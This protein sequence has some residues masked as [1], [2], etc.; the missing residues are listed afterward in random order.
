MLSGDL[1]EFFQQKLE[2]LRVKILDFSRTNPLINTRMGTSYQNYIRVI[3]EHPEIILNG[4]EFSEFELTPLPKLEDEP[5]DELNS[6]FENRFKELLVT[7]ELYFEELLRLEEENDTSQDSLQKA[8]RELKDRIR[9]ELKMPPRVKRDSLNLRQHA[10]NNDINPN[11]DLPTPD[12]TH[13]DGRHSDSKIQTLLLPKDLERL[14]GKIYSRGKSS[15]LE[16]GINTLHAAFGFLEWIELDGEKEN[17]SPLVIMPLNLQRRPSADGIKYLIDSIGE[18]GKTNKV[19]KEKLKQ[20]YQIEFP[21]F[22]GTSIEDYF[23]I[24]DNL[25]PKNFSK[26]NIKRF[27][28]FGNF[29][30]AQM[31]MFNDLKFDNHDYE[32]NQLVQDLLIGT[33]TSLQDHSFAEDYNNDIPEIENEVPNLVMDADSSQFS[34]LVDIQRGKNLAIEGPPGTGKS[35]TIVNAIVSAIASGKKVLFVAQK[36]AALEVVLA[37]IKS[38]GLED[39]VLPL[40]DLQTNRGKLIGRIKKRIEISEKDIKSKLSK[41]YMIDHQSDIDD[42]REAREKLLLYI[43]ILKSEIIEGFTVHDIFGK[44]IRLSEIILKPEQ[45]N[46]F[47]INNSLLLSKNKIEKI[48][49]E[50]REL[51][52][53]WSSCKNINSFWSKIKLVNVNKFIIDEILSKSSELSQSVQEFINLFPDNFNEDGTLNNSKLSQAAKITDNYNTLK[54]YL[55]K[56]DIPFSL[57]IIRNG[58]TKLAQDYL[59]LKIKIEEVETGFDELF[60]TP[61]NDDIQAQLKRDINELN[62]LNI[63]KLSTADFKLEID[64][65]IENQKKNNQTFN[66][67]IDFFNN[68]PSLKKCSFEGIKKAHEIISKT[69]DNVLFLRDKK[70]ENP[71]ALPALKTAIDR[72]N[73]INALKERLNNDFHI[74]RV[75]SYDILV[76]NIAFLHNSGSF[77]FFSSEKK[78]AK[79]LFETVVKKYKFTKKYAIKFFQELS[80]YKKLE[81]TLFSNN[82]LV[83]LLGEHNDGI[84]TDF[85]SHKETCE[86]F[87]TINN[88]FNDIND[89]PLVDFLKNQPLNLLNSIPNLTGNEVENFSNFEKIEEAQIDLDNKIKII[90]NKIQFIDNNFS[91]LKNKEKITTDLLNTFENNYENYNEKLIKFNN[92]KNDSKFKE[93]DLKHL[94]QI[95]LDDSIKLV[96][97]LDNLEFEKEKTIEFLEKNQIEH[98]A[99]NHENY[100]KYEEIVN[101]KIKNYLLE[102]ELEYNFIDNDSFNYSKFSED[103]LIASNERTNLENFAN[104]NKELA[105]FSNKEILR[106]IEYQL[107][108]EHNL[109]DIELKVEALIFRDL[110]I[111]IYKKFEEGLSGY[112]GEN[113]KNLRNR[114]RHLDKQIIESNSQKVKLD[115]LQN[116]NPETGNGIGKSSS[117]TGMSLLYHEIEKKAGHKPP[118]FLIDKAGDALMEIMPCWTMPPLNIA[119]YLKSDIQKFDLCIIDEAS[120]MIPGYA[121]GA[122]LRSKQC[123]IVGDVNQMPPDNTFMS[124]LI[125][126]EQNEDTEIKEESILE[127]ANVTFKPRRRLK[128]HYRSEDSSLIAFSNRYIYEDELILFPSSSE[129]SK[130]EDMGVSLV[131][132]D[133]IYKSSINLIEANKIVEYATNF[134]KNYPKRSLGIVSMNIQQTDLILSLIDTAQNTFKHVRE[135]IEYWDKVNEGLERFIVKNLASIQGDERDTILI[136]TVYGPET[137]G[138]PVAQR[139]GPINGNSG[140]RRLNVLFSRAKKQIITFTS[141]K[142]SDLKTNK[143]N[144][145]GVKLL[146][147]WLEY[148]QTRIID[149]GE[150]SNKKPDS[151]FEIYVMEQI[152]KMGYQAVPQVGAAGYFIDIGVKHPDWDYGYIMGVECDGRQY[153]SSLSARDRDRLRQ[154]ILEKLGWSFHRIW[155]TDWFNTRDQ[156]IKRLKTRLDEKLEDL[157]AGRKNIVN[158]TIEDLNLELR[159]EEI[160]NLLDENSPDQNNVS[161][162]INKEQFNTALENTKHSKGTEEYYKEVSEILDEQAV[163]IEKEIA[164]NAKPDKFI[165]VQDEI[166]LEYLD[167][168]KGVFEF[169]IYEI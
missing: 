95:K 23:T 102:Y 107:F 116:C 65:L 167:G 99:Q 162:E 54:E 129:N 98:I 46:N 109:D 164:K 152:E 137:P 79:T 83:N 40:Q 20:Q 165:Q 73:S 100:L 8:Q 26:W 154:N 114:V 50:C 4:L 12:D 106:L 30:S 55:M 110:M 168:D 53:K 10:K 59:D 120:Q 69:S 17:L 91:Y 125:D 61:P 13:D 29:P 126:I 1:L 150:Q 157:K 96:K 124:Q 11:Y 127:I 62:K 39:F 6:E 28:S 49:A 24:I 42:F 63:V 156:E 93:I 85:E 153:H 139:F 80:D 15:E 166:T 77:S 94:N 134:M 105:N 84:N 115:L 169:I 89:Q 3:D 68:Y 66:I 103:L 35:Q 71:S 144:N 123:I 92:I 19:L 136:S 90:S 117:Y 140:K 47:S 9:E 86:F 34:A 88:S 87:E 163:K 81:E 41:D 119:R 142:P 38:L 146:N 133:G 57:W 78:E 76:K 25:K 128:W 135:Y 131:K 97:I 70:Y 22:D 67:L 155:S 122:L 118:R 82:L 27:I 74:D 132:L 51:E 5:K 33:D 37:R 121:L 112:N 16:T 75:P 158:S 148:S 2:N 44:N 18:K 43:N 160:S 159:K 113:L 58:S 14:A 104:F 60:M 21:E 72:V 111:E 145:E 138:G 56:S 36:L 161:K 31:S 147:K 108:K 143:T 7:D 48:L 151:D 130:I 101:K 52:G 64:D 32:N 141:M 45:I 149:A